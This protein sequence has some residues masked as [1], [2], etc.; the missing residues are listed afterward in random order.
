MKWFSLLCQCN[1]RTVVAKT[2]GYNSQTPFPTV[3][4]AMILNAGIF[5]CSI[6]IID[7]RGCI[8]FGIVHLRTDSEETG[9]GLD[10]LPADGSPLSDWRG[11]PSGGWF[12]SD[13]NGL[14]I[15][16]IEK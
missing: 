2:E 5:E 4:S 6:E 13:K 3:M 15:S 7:L 8:S 9:K 1:D 12:E 16:N 10:P 11:S 14:V